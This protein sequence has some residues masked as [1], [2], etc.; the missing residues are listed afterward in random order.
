MSDIQELI[1][2]KKSYISVRSIESKSNEYK[3]SDV[4]LHIQNMIQ[5]ILGDGDVR[6]YFTEEYSKKLTNDIPT[7]VQYDRF[8]DVVSRYGKNYSVVKDSFVADGCNYRIDIKFP[9]DIELIG[10]KYYRIFLTSCDL[11]QLKIDNLSYIDDINDLLIKN[12]NCNMIMNKVSIG[13][14]IIDKEDI[15][16]RMK[17]SGNLEGLNEYKGKRMAMHVHTQGDISDE[18]KKCGA[19]YNPTFQF[20]GDISGE[21][22][23][24][25]FGNIY[26]DMNGQSNFV[27]YITTFP[28]PNDILLGKMIGRSIVLHS[29]PDDLGEGDNLESSKSGNSGKRVACGILGGLFE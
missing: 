27:I 2:K 15:K 23:L 14:I 21:R 6:S 20:H 18:C 13:S 3:N 11:E 1:F 10:D 24:G 25:D 26:V 29:D 7:K 9:S 8:A 28:L 4:S 16:Y 12:L 5:S 17:V 22:H 19:H